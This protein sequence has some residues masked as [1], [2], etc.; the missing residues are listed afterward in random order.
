VNGEWKDVPAGL[1]VRGQTE[2]GEEV[3]LPAAHA[4]MVISVK[5]PAVTA[6]T[7]FFQG[8]TSTGFFPCDIWQTPRWLGQKIAPERFS[9]DKAIDAIEVAGHLSDTIN[10]VAKELN[11]PYAGYGK[12]GVCMDTVAVVRH[13]LTKKN[14]YWPLLMR[15]ELLFPQMEKRLTDRKR[16]DDDEFARLLSSMKAVENDAYDNPT[17]AARMLS[18]IPWSKGQEPFPAIVL[19]RRLLENRD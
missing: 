18:S 16:S 17:S 19:V 4:E 5:G 9:G 14:D 12:L 2:R 15:D 6:N 13:A 7:K 11:L 10:A 1:L 3:A 8:M